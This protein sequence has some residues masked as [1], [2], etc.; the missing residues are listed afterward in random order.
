MAKSGDVVVVAF[1]FGTSFSGYAFSF[2]NEPS[3]VQTNG[4]WSAGS[5]KL[6]SLKTPTCVLLNKDDEFHSFGYEAENKYSELAENGD[7]NG[8]KLFKLFKMELHN[9][10]FS[11]LLHFSYYIWLARLGIV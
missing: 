8:W 11:A 2:G 7:H 9:N 1:D 3:K 4:S 5:E 6:M 10:K